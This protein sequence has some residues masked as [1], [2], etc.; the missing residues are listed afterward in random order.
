MKMLFLNIKDY[1]KIDL[2]QLIQIMLIALCLE[3]SLLNARSLKKD[4]VDISRA[5]QITENDIVCLT[6]SQITN[7]TDV[8]EVLEQ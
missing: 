2:I 4:A 3:M 7:N 8:T 1:K 6:E 5:R